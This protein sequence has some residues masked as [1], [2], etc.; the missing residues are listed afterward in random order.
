M[1]IYEKL[2]NK[3]D[4]EIYSFAGP[5]AGNKEFAEFSNRNIKDICFRY[6]NELD[7]VPLAWNESDLHKVFN[8]YGDITP[9]GFVKYLFQYLINAAKGK[10]YMQIDVGKKI[11]GSIDN[12]YNIYIHQVIYQH[13][14][15]Y[16]KI[17]GLKL[18]DI[19]LQDD[20]KRLIKMD[21]IFKDIEEHIL[22]L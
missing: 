5:T 15:G 10:G 11:S 19:L 9:K 17:A 20:I 13:V 14:S 16:L 3:A 6:F 4:I 8:L 18:S 12:S 22:K 21:S 2:K 1:G 7:I